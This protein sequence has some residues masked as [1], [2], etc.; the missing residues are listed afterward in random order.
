MKRNNKTI[1]W[2]VVGI[3]LAALLWY[4]LSRKA[5]DTTGS[6]TGN[7]GSGTGSGSS[8]TGSSPTVDPE[9][10][11]K[12]YIYHK[13]SRGEEVKFIQWHLN[14]DLGLN[15]DIDG[16]W[17]PK[18]QAAWERRCNNDDRLSKCGLTAADYQMI[19]KMIEDVVAAQNAGVTGGITY[20]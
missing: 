20:N 19:K 14:E 2:I 3:G 17:G 11:N 8:G 13:G 12:G 5:K 15:L 18:T 7:G 9:C 4:I 10:A 16:I 1:V 6:G